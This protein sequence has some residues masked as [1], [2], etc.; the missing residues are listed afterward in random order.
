MEMRFL[1]AHLV[2]LRLAFSDIVRSTPRANPAAAE[3]KINTACG[4]A[5]VANNRCVATGSVFW[6]TRIATKIATIAA[7][8]S[9]RS[10]IRLSLMIPGEP[11]KPKNHNTVQAK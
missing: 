2:F 4:I 11:A 5:T 3:M 1:V 7:V 9:F 8:M 6:M 10:R